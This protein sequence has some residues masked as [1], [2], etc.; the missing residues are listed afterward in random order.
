[1]QKI[2]HVNDPQKPNN[3]IYVGRPQDKRTSHFGN[4]F[5]HLNYS[6]GTI[7]VPSKKDCTQRYKTW[8]LGETDKNLEQERRKWIIKNLNLIYNANSLETW[9]VPN[10]NHKDY[11]H[12]MKESDAFVLQTL[13]IEQ[14][15]KLEGNQTTQ[16]NNESLRIAIV[17]TAGR[18]DDAEKLYGDLFPLF[19]QKT[20]QTIQEISKKHPHKKIELVSG[21]A[22]WADHI[23]VQLFLQKKADTLEL[24]LPTKLLPT[25]QF[26]EETEFKSPGNVANYWHKKFSQ[27]LY[28]TKPANTTIIEINKAITEGAKANINYGFKNRNTD[29]A[30]A[31]YLIALTF[32]H[33][34]EVKKGGTEDTCR[35]FIENKKSNE[36]SYHIDLHTTKIFHKITLPPPQKTTA[37][38]R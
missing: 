24:N 33:E 30:N 14:N 11:E 2:V 6:Q 35:K 15:K 37:F 38:I 34:N 8:L 7:L 28:P 10:Q 20:L 5:S 9:D 29:V 16:S 13:A 18:K 1:M 32:G 36:N 25:N 17:G 3:G 12:K 22:A 4:P 26:Q 21:G 27:A 31:D 23:A 19:I